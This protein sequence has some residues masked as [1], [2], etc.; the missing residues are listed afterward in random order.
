VMTLID[1][2]NREALALEVATSIP[3]TRVIRVLEELIA[4]HGRP[5]A[6]RVDNGPER[7]GNSK[8]RTC[9]ARGGLVRDWC[10]RPG[11]TRTGFEGGGASRKWKS[12]SQAICHVNSEKK[13]RQESGRDLEEVVV[14]A[15][16]AAAN[17][18]K[19]RRGERPSEQMS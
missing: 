13:C 8:Q 15:R 2:G 1:E 7:F 10:R 9:A 12:T 3:A 16:S 5:L 4:L 6:I 14:S 17:L 11:R 18:A 19:E